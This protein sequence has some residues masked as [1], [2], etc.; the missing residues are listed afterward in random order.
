MQPV[1]L[2]A[3]IG[4]RWQTAAWVFGL[5]DQSDWA[6]LHGSRQNSGNVTH[7]LSTKIDAFGLFTGQLG[8]AWNNVLLYAKGGAAVVDQRYDFVSNATGLAVASGD[9]NTR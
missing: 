9:Y 6:D 3:Q 2:P 7:Q 5:E 4:Y 8:Y 1:R